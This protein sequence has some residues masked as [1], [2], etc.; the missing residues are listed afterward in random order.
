[1][2][3]TVADLLEVMDDLYPPGVAEPWDRV[4]LTVGSRSATVSSV[5]F[6]VDCTDAVVAEAVTLGADLVVAHHPLLL[7]GIHAVDSDHPKGRL[8][9]ELV[10]RGISLVVAHTNADKPRG[11][12]VDALA[13]A[14]G[15]RETE[16]L[17]AD[18]HRAELGGLGRVGRLARPV[19]LEDFVR[20]VAG[21]LPSTGGGIRISGDLERIITT[22]AVQAGA[23]DDLLDAAR[24]AG[25][26]V[27]V[28][29]DLRHHPAGEARAWT[30]AP[31]L[32]DVPHW[33]AEW[34]WLPVVRSQ[35]AAA[36]AGRTG[37]VST[38]VSSL[39]T[40]PWDHVVVGADPRSP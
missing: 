35:L 12:V 30:D 20:R 15:L 33:A 29:S 1:M 27:Y 6:T 10:S 28:T 40:D 8:V 21:A 2:S 14:L 31:A 4:G 38:A 13:G 23:G 11:G 37:R 9:T 5:L 17:R 7:K 19:R 3:L 24:E 18:D 32:I 22:V 36:V 26:D 34:T 16:P 39:V 25:A